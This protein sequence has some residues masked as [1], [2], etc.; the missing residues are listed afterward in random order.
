MT[1]NTIHDLIAIAEMQA[2]AERERT[3]LA[4]QDARDAEDRADAAEQQLDYT[5]LRLA[6]AE[7][8]LQDVTTQYAATAAI[9]LALI[10]E[11]E[12]AGYRRT[13]A[14]AQVQTHILAFP[15]DAS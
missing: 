14:V 3:A 7:R 4:E 5:L 12:R 13:P 2:A 9:A 11:L 1:T 15:K 10:A 8:Q 6:Q